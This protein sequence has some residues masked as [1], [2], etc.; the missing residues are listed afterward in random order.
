MSTQHKNQLKYIVALY[1]TYK[2]VQYTFAS[3]LLKYI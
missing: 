2:I 3:H 1:N